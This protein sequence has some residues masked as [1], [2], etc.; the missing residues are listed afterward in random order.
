M[1]GNV[2][3]KRMYAL[4]NT[5]S[6]VAGEMAVATALIRA[7]HRVA[8]P[9]WNDDEVDIMIFERDGLSLLPIP[10]QV[11]SIQRL[12]DKGSEFATQG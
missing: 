12:D 3:V 5:Y 10:V 8:K 7:G 6:G 4:K 11:K 2:R 1:N 9:Y